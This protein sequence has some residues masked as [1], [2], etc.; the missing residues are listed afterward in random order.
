MIEGSD[1]GFPWLLIGAVT[2]D[3]GGFGSREGRGSGNVSAGLSMTSGGRL[4]ATSEGKC[5]T[6]SGAAGGG[7]ERGLLALGE[8]GAAGWTAANGLEARAAGAWAAGVEAD[9]LERCGETGCGET[10]GLERSAAVG[11]EPTTGAGAGLGSR[12]IDGA[13]AVLGSGAVTSSGGTLRRFGSLASSLGAGVGMGMRAAGVGSS[14]VG[15]GV[16]MRGR[17]GLGSMGAGVGIG[18]RARA[19]TLADEAAP[20][21]MLGN[22][23]IAPC[24]GTEGLAAGLLGTRC[25]TKAGDSDAGRPGGG[26]LDENAAGSGGARVDDGAESNRSL[27]TSCALGASSSKPVLARGDEATLGATGVA[28]GGAAGVFRSSCP[29]GMS[30]ATGSI[31]SVRS[32]PPYGTPAP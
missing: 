13:M 10:A 16:G 28:T 23:T 21:S 15:V 4:V 9:G 30:S 6:P 17:A 18:A 7:L 27:S 1:C 14:E 26:R 11:L 19:S 32:S 31:S 22:A 29:N 8:L 24:F 3:I 12:A 25:C 5:A 2:A 20:T